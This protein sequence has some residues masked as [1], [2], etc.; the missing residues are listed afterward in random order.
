M[1]V[2]RNISYTFSSTALHT[3][4]NIEVYL[5]VLCALAKVTRPCMERPEREQAELTGRRGN[6]EHPNLFCSNGLTKK[7]LAATNHSGIPNF[8]FMGLNDSLSVNSHGYQAIRSQNPWGGT[9][10]AFAQS[11]CIAY[12]L[13][14][15]GSARSCCGYSDEVMQQVIVEIKAMQL[16]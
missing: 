4:I 10:E 8:T 12:I 2:R 6:L 1:T 16:I 15:T 11:F 13:R 3:Y 9:L 5:H 7:P 14:P